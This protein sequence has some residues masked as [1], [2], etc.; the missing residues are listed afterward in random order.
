MP[1]K[2]GRSVSNA[3][4]TPAAETPIAR[5]RSGSQQQADAAI[6]ETT[7][8]AAAHMVAGGSPPE[9]SATFVT[10]AGAQQSCPAGTSADAFMAA[11]TTS[12][13]GSPFPP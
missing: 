6:A 1:R 4:D 12:R 9:V 7:E 8:P 3:D 5:R 11:A 10:P 2:T 13:V